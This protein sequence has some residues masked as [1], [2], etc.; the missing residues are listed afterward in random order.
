MP[1][2]RTP[3]THSILS[4]KYMIILSIYTSYIFTNFTYDDILMGFPTYNVTGTF[5]NVHFHP[6]IGTQG[7]PNQ[8]SSY[9]WI[10]F[11]RES[12]SNIKLSCCGLIRSYRNLP[13]MY[14]LLHACGLSY[15]A[16]HVPTVG[17]PS[18]CLHVLTFA[19]TLSDLIP[20]T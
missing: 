2:Q 19:W 6:L 1:V 20:Q 17:Y 14:A 11:D 18:V 16:L 8:S 5:S 9:D 12:L 4:N 10:M 3:T 15:T 13:Y 7:V